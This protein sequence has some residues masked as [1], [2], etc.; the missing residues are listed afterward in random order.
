MVVDKIFIDWSTGKMEIDANTTISV[1][2]RTKVFSRSTAYDVDDEVCFSIIRHDRT[3]DLEAP[4]KVSRDM[5]VDGLELYVSH[6]VAGN[7]PPNVPRL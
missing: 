6:L 7:K 4:S 1:G 2:K 5:W 3:L